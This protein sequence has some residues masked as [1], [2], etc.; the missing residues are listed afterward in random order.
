MKISI[1]SNEITLDFLEAARIGIEWGIRDYEI[2]Y[3]KSGRVPYISEDEIERLIKIKNEFDLNISAISP[4]L[5]KISLSDEVQLKLEIEEHIYESFRLAE[6]FGT[7]NVIIFGFMK[8]EKEP[9]TNYVQVLHILGRMTSLAEK[10][11]FKL[12]LE[13]HPG[14]WADTSANTAKILDDVNS[15]H[16]RANW[17]LANAAYAG[18]IPYPYGYLTIRHH[19]Y[20][21]HVKDFLTNK[22]GEPE[23][24]V[25]G[26]GTIDWYGQLKAIINN[27][28][29]KYLTIET[30][31]KPLIENS[32][33]NLFRVTNMLKDLEMD[34][35]FVLK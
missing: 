3:L 22:N 30:Q 10:Y 17:D 7:N 35:K 25:F 20:S 14:F 24:T 19:I 33:R 21:I 27:K 15:K 2:R 11:G 13:N 12:L 16:L 5:F 34:D 9:Q 26:D 8:Y 28:E 4:G 18:E 31:V 6:K 32:N 1:I 29:V 23:F